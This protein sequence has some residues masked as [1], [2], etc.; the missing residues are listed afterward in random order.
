MSEA[1][2]NTRRTPGAGRRGVSAAHKRKDWA[3]LR[4]LFHPKALIGTF[5][6]GG[7]PENPELAL[8]RLRDAHQD[9]ID[10]ADVA[11]MTELD[12]QAVLLDGRVPISRCLW[13][14]GRR[15]LLALRRS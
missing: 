5:A 7:R 4:T 8:S 2:S 14:G 15:A 3:F 1:M 9:F 12:D 10:H 13:H 6:G 11:H